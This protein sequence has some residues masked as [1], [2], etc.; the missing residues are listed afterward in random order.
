MEKLHQSVR[1]NFTPPPEY[2]V[3]RELLP[4]YGLYGSGM[5]GIQ[6]IRII[7]LESQCEMNKH[8]F[9]TKHDTCKD[10]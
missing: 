7:S 4:V 8:A 9:L 10:L 1:P 6:P 5:Y 2:M 3:L